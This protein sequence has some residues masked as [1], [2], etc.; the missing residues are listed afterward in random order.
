MLSV[1]MVYIN[2]LLR[3][4]KV[5]SSAITI[6]THFQNR[7]SGNWTKIFQNPVREW[8]LDPALALLGVKTATLELS[9]GR[10]DV[11]HFTTLTD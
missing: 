2:V 11:M 9:N 6:Y 5:N 10:Y 3:D 8:K 7:L 1:I 4:D